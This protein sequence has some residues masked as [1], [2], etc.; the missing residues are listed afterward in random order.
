MKLRTMYETAYQAGIAA[1]PR[2]PEG[3]ARVL[4][5]TRKEFDDLPERRRWE[6]DQEAL[7]N[8]YADTRILA[9][10][11]E[12]RRSRRSWWASTSRWAR[13]C[14]PTALRAK[15]SSGRPAAGPPPRGPGA[16][17]TGRGHGPAGRHMA[18]LRS[19]DGL[20]A[21]RS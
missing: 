15:G 17:A 18:Q 6:F 10:R 20:S 1:D 2:G 13:C 5:R 7:M 4:E 8:P 14:W 12:T 21:T 9:G 16:G 11:P 19:V 3:V